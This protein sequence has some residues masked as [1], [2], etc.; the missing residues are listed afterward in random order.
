MENNTIPPYERKAFYYETDRMGVVHHSN[1]IRW[2]EETR[3]YYLEKA[4]Y[5]YSEMEADGVLIPVLSAECV[6]KNNVRFDETVY[7]KAEPE[8]FNGFRMSIRY[9][10]TGADGTLKA[11]GKTSHCFVD[12]SFK[13]IRVKKTHPRVYET[14]RKIMPADDQQE[15]Q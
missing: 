2:F 15:D 12:A 1:Y 13:P 14:F 9:T 8:E 6:Y 4:G 7:I 5:P 10:V 3:V 11:T